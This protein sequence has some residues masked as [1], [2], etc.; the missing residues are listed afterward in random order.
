M[1]L[2]RMTH[3]RHNNS[4]D[5]NIIRKGKEGKRLFVEKNFGLSLHERWPPTRLSREQKNCV[6]SS[7]LFV[8]CYGNVGLSSPFLFSALVEI[9]IC[10]FDTGWSLVIRFSVIEVE[11]KELDTVTSV[12]ILFVQNFKNL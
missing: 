5:N 6:Q 10:F 12:N 1:A 4:N 9:V 2:N 11:R 7:F 8:P 3:D